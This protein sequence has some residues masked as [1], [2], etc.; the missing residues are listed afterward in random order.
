VLLCSTFCCTASDQHGPRQCH[1]RSCGWTLWM[2]RQEQQQHGS[3]S[4]SVDIGAAAIT[5]MPSCAILTAHPIGF[6]QPLLDE[7]QWLSLRGFSC[8]CHSAPALPSPLHSNV[9]P[10]NRT[11]AAARPSCCSRQFNNWLCRR[12]LASVKQHLMQ[13]MMQQRHVVAQLAAAAGAIAAAAAAAAAAAVAAV[14][15]AVALQQQV[16]RHSR[17]VAAVRPLLTPTQGLLHGPVGP[18]HLRLEL[19]TP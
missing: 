11:D 12:P 3:S 5:H 19:L 2:L 8:R 1:T 13:Q 7:L 18:P 17:L 14:A 15:V 4:S 9:L 16:G 10:G 6:P